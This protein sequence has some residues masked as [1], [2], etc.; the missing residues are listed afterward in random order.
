MATRAAPP[1]HLA[2]VLA[3][4]ST[5]FVVVRSDEALDPDA[6]LLR[7]GCVHAGVDDDHRDPRPVRLGD[8]GDDLLGPTRSDAE[9]VDSGLDEVLDDLHLLVHV[10]L[11]L[12][13]LHHDPNAHPACG[14]LRPPLH[15]D[16]EGAVQR[17]EH[18]GD[19]RPAGLGRLPPVAGARQQ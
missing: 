3:R 10:D 4:P 12:G 2:H 11:A 6:R 17:L 14:L 13:R 15:V 8:G 5:P 9:H 18:E 7:R 16:E 19:G 1:T